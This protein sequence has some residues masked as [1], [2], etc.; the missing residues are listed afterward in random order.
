LF[1]VLDAG[2]TV[3]A[4]GYGAMFMQADQVPG[5]VETSA[6]SPSPPWTS[7]YF[8]LPEAGKTVFRTFGVQ[9][10]AELGKA[11]LQRN[12][13]DGQDVTLITH[14]AS[15]V[16]MDIWKKQINPYQY[17]D[18]LA[19]WGNMVSA[20]VPVNFAHAILDPKTAILGQDDTIQKDYVLFLNP[21]AE[22]KAVGLL[23][24]RIP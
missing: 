1:S 14:Q 13:L 5:R 18:T 10:P 23:L 2:T 9:D 8:H 24:K 12:G 20:T 6:G 21:S 22:F 19:S 4:G 17:I 3:R 11:I 15:K 16:L 7:P